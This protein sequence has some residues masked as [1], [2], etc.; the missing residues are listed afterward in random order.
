MIDVHI[1]DI[2]EKM[3]D[4]FCKFGDLFTKV[5]KINGCCLDSIHTNCDGEEDPGYD[6]LLDPNNKLIL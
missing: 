2:Y 1:K 6:L 3:S 5:I 4:L